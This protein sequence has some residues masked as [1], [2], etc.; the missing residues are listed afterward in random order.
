M[1]SAAVVDF[2]AGLMPLYDGER[3]DRVWCARSLEDGTLMI[4]LPAAEDDDPDNA[5]VRVRWQGTAAGEQIVSGRYVATIAV[6]RYVQ[7][8]ATGQPA[9]RT[10]A[11]LAHMSQHFTFKTGLSLYLPYE[12]SG[13]ELVS[14]VRKAVGRIGESAVVN[15]LTK[16]AGF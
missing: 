14:A 5:F 9:E 4:P 2:I 16:A 8:H 7:F 1:S 11:E 13:P 6:V 10:A 3:L 15:V 12:T